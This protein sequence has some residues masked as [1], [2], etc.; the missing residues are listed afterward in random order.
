MNLAEQ[1][2][3]AVTRLPVCILMLKKCKKP[4]DVP[5]INA[6]EHFVKGK[7]QNQLTDQHIENIVTPYQFRKEQDRYARRASMKEIVEND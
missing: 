1:A 7:R 4:D 2:A 3:N 5:F 6:A